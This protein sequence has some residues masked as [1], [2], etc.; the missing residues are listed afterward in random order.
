MSGANEVRFSLK[1]M[2]NKEKSKVLLARVDS[3]FA[4]V[5]LSFL[6]LP[7]GRIMRLLIEHYVD[8]APAMGSLNTLYTGLQNLD[9]VYFW[10]KTGKEM[11]LDPRTPVE[12]EYQ[13]L[14]LNVYRAQPTKYFTCACS[15]PSFTISPYSEDAICA[16]CKRLLNEEVEVEP[17]SASKN[18]HE[19]FAPQHTSFIICDDLQMLPNAPGYVL[20][21]LT[22]FG[23]MDM[24]G[25]EYNTVTVGFNEVSQTYRSIS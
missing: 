12:D 21:T 17:L 18:S 6:T 11:L 13:K 7:L 22:A 9:C 20:Q 15:F 19:V 14:K 24:D 4:D 5:L 2:I 10:T 25:A 16:K 23:I 8:K 1:L 3:A